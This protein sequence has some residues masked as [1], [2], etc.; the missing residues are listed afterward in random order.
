M[1]KSPCDSCTEGPC[2]KCRLVLSD[3]CECPKDC[4]SDCSGCRY[5]WA[6]NDKEDKHFC[7]DLLP[8]GCCQKRENVFC[9]AA[10]RGGTCPRKK[11]LPKP[12]RVAAVQFDNDGKAEIVPDNDEVMERCQ[13]QEEISWY[14]KDHKAT[15]QMIS[16]AG[17]LLIGAF[18]L[19]IG[20]I[21]CEWAWFGIK[22]AIA[23]DP[24]RRI[25]LDLFMYCST[26][27]LAMVYGIQW[28]SACLMPITDELS[29]AWKIAGRYYR[30]AVRGLSEAGSDEL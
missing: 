24:S 30:A 29:A 1:T 12:T 9:L 23:L 4:T 15:Q 22:T 20:Y 21:I 8:D 3:R 17:S 2:R 26:S 28:W 19:A 13:L 11:I 10:I 27:L 5:N 16:I 7:M 14:R 6:R 18:F 25:T